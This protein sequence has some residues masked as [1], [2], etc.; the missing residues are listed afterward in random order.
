VEGVLIDDITDY[1]RL[2]NLFTIYQSTGKWLQTSYV[3]FDTGRTMTERASLEIEPQLFNSD[4]HF[5]KE[6]PGG[7]SKRVVMTLDLLSLFNQTSWVPAWAINGGIDVRL[8]LSDPLSVV[9]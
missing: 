6:I 2:V 5:S 1:N 9:N 7:K 4:E 3:G 8:T